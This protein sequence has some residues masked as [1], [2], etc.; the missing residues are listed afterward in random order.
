MS[1]FSILSRRNFSILFRD[2]VSLTLTLLVSPI[3]A[4]LDFLFWRRGLFAADGGDA[5]FALTNLFMAAMVCCLVGALSSMREIVKEADIYQRERM[6]V[7]KIVPY[8]LSKV[9]LSVLLAL[10]SSAVFILF[11]EL[12]GGWPPFDITP[13]VYLTMVLSILGGALMGLFV[14]ALSPNPNV[15]PLLLLLVLVPQLLFGGIIPSG[16]IGRAGNI[17]GYATTTKWTFESLVKIS[18][19]GDDVSGDRCWNIT[20]GEREALTEKDKANMCK[21][22]GVNIFSECDFPGV[23]NYYVDEIDVPEPLKPAKPESPVDPKEM[24]S[25]DENMSQ[26]QADLDTWQQKYQ[27]WKERRSKAIGEAEGAIQAI[28]ND[29]GQAFKTNVKSNWLLLSAIT[30]VLFCMV[31]GVLKWKDKR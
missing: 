31:L 11:L 12:S 13:A 16:Q 19:M 8:V 23:R 20:D 15:T 5:R 24:Q 22:M 6:V 28:Y 30:L 7:L 1:Q 25:Y 10:Y 4:M 2:K 21:C 26:Y 18:G 3:I 27:D 9:W 14:S 29:Y 17:I